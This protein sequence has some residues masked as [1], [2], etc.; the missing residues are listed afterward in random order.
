MGQCHKTQLKKIRQARGL[1]QTQLAYDLGVSKATY[2]SWES[3]RIELG[4]NRIVALAE[5]LY[6]TP[7]DILG[8]G[9]R[10]TQ[11]EPDGY[12]SL[13]DEERRFVTLLR[14]LPPNI[15]HDVLDIM[16]TTVKG[17]RISNK[18]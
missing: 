1:T 14:S 10:A 12:V 6:C 9:G 15:K 4:A 18:G 7:N 2:S 11:A 5:R 8:C 3:G 13:T 17:W 16:Q